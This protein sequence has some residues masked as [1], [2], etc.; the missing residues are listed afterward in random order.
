MNSKIF[1]TGFHANHSKAA[2]ICSTT[3]WTHRMKKQQG[4]MPFRNCALP[5]HFSRFFCIEDIQYGVFLYKSFIQR[6]LRSTCDRKL[7][8]QGY[9]HQYFCQETTVNLTASIAGLPSG[10]D[11]NWCLRMLYDLTTGCKSHICLRLRRY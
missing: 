3:L 6:E 10:R 2:Y 4:I 8:G 1:C 11:L 5:I 9:S 7:G